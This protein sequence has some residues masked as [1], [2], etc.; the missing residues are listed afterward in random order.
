M[1]DEHLVDHRDRFSCCYLG[2]PAHQEQQWNHGKKDDPEQIKRVNEGH[3]RGFSY[4]PFRGALHMPVAA[5]SRC[6]HLLK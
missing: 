5:R 6:H 3:E 2:G 1:R 4:R